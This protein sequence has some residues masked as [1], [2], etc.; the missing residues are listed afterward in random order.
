QQEK[1]QKEI[2][3]RQTQLKSLYEKGTVEPPR[4]VLSGNATNNDNESSQPAFSRITESQSAK[5]ADEMIKND[6]EIYRMEA[7]L[8]A[9]KSV[10]QIAEQQ[11][12]SQLSKQQDEQR[13]QQIR[14]EFKRDP[15]VIALCDEIALA[16]DRRQHARS[17]VRQGNDPERR[18]AEER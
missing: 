13:E 2:K 8:N 14:D 17:A 3:D 18:A 1:I 15:D 7:D 4:P 5:L 10:S 9:Y 16:D 12:K 11:D 6:L